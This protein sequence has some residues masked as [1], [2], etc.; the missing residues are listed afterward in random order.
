[1]FPV[2]AVAEKAGTFVNWEG[3]G[4]TFEEALPVPEVRTDL[5]VLGAI[6]DEMDVHLGLPDQA[7]A[8]A[9]LAALGRWKGSRPQPPQVPGGPGGSP[10]RNTQFLGVGGASVAIGDLASA[11]GQRADAGWR[12]VPG[13][14]RPSGGRPD[15]SGHR[16]PGRRSRW[17]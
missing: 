5:Y 4:G 6:A 7:A 13:R 16:G 14:Y 10:S 17:R 2:A 1:V 8:R 12:A 9:E 3:R 15:V 11:A